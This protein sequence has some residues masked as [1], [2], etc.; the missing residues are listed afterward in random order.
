MVQG[1]QDRDRDASITIFV[2][3]ANRFPQN[4]FINRNRPQNRPVVEIVV[5]MNREAAIAEFTQHFGVDPF[6]FCDAESILE[7]NRDEF[8]SACSV[9]QYAQGQNNYVIGM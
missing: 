8:F 9:E 5:L 4:L 6:Q 3:R 1:N 2:P 7:L